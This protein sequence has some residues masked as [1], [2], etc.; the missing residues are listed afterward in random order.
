MGAVER[1]NQTIGGLLRRYSNE[2]EH[3]WDGKLPA[4]LFSYHNTI[5]D[6]TGYAPFFLVHGRH[7]ETLLDLEIPMSNHLKT[8]QELAKFLEENMRIIHEQIRMHRKD[9]QEK[10]KINHDKH[11]TQVKFIVGDQILIKVGVKKVVAYQI[12]VINQKREEREEK[13]ERRVER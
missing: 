7:P 1:F 6:T 11:A 12:Q 4:V 10:T 3:L 2:E 8:H 5:H 13:E 9:K